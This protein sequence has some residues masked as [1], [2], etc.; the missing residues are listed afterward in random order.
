V[1]ATAGEASPTRVLYRRKPVLSWAFYDW[2]NSAF[3]TTVMAG[4]FPAFFQRYW[5]LGV[6]P[7]VSTSRLGLAN[8]IAGFFVALLAPVLGA[9]ADRGG[10]RRR[11]LIAWSLLGIVGTALLFFV[12]QGAWEL[13]AALFVVGSIGF[14]AANVFY[15]ALLLDVAAEH[16]LDRVSAF[17]YSLGYLGG[18]LLFAINVAMTVKPEW[19]GLPDIAAAI[20]LSFLMVAVWWAVFL[21]PLALNVREAPPAA[22]LPFAAAARAGVTELIATLRQITRYQQI[23][24]FLLAYWLYIDAVNTIIK[25]AVDYGVALGL[26]TASLLAALLLTQ[27]VAF[28]AAL[29]F[30]WLGDRIGAKRGILIGIAV[31]SV[32]TVYAFFLDSVVEFFALAVVIGLVQGGVQSLSRSLFGR[33][34]PP[35]KGGE[36]FGFYNMMGKFATVVGPLLVAGVALTTGSSRASIASLVVLFVAGG[37]LLTLV[38]EPASAP[39]PGRRSG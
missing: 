15:D 33:L 12:E 20:R 24:I 19:F 17:G 11:F 21:L 26:P 18:G 32:A 34:V 27:F 2:A 30:G 8:G 28:P 25:M 9:I 7:T 3:A 5:S 22:P 4:F 14:A 6:D 10:V 35:G 1:G 38:R 13:A 39:D 29:A 23:G 36:F 31:Y 37:L 16:E